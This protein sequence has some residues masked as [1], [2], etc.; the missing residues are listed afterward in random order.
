[1]SDDD[2]KPLPGRFVRTLKTA[3]L[4][5]SIGSRYAL[6]RIADSM[7]SSPDQ[8]R[9]ARHLENAKRVVATMTELR[10]PLLKVGQLLSAHL[11]ALPPEYAAVL[12]PLQER[13]R[14]MGFATVR[15]VVETQLGAD[16]ETLF[17]RFEREATAAASLGQVHRAALH[18]GTEVAVK[19][20]YP[21]AQIAMAGDVENIKLA[22][23]FTR[24]VVAEMLGDSRLD[25]TAFADELA[26]HLLQETDYCREAYNAKLLRSLFEGDARIVVPRVHDARSS[27]L[28]VTY[29]WVEGVGIERALDEGDVEQRTRVVE[30]LAH[31]FWRQLLVGGVLHADPH[32]GNYRVLADGRLGMLDHGC[33]KIFDEAFLRSFVGLVRARMYGDE[34]A[35]RAAFLALGLFEEGAPAEE[36]EGLRRIADYCAAGLTERGP[37]D[38]RE[39]GYLDRARELVMHFASQRRPPPAQRDFLFLSRVVLGHHEYFSR[40]RV[41]IDY[42]ALVEPYVEAGFTRRGI[43]IPDYD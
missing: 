33:V 38:F 5:G 32:P 21:G 12:K 18:D 23:A 22:G 40:A 10:G 4:G 35:T 13:V 39:Y 43:A 20:Q 16:L 17:A 3:W 34:P 28:V 30:H 1:M 11:D 14:P 36:L 29:D 41:A 2:R 8:D 27:L 25:L 26:L 37:F 7:R 42:R 19:V 6:G 9:G 31:A 24:K 15:D